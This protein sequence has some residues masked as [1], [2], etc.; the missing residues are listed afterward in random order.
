MEHLETRLQFGSYFINSTIYFSLLVFY[1]VN[2][3]LLGTYFS[4]IKFTSQLSLFRVK[5]VITEAKLANSCSKIQGNT[6]KM[7]VNITQS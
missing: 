5:P 4:F 6:D 1:F 2:C 3:I 7:V